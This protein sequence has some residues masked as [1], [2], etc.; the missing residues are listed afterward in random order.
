MV[1]SKVN[2]GIKSDQIVSEVEKRPCLYD[3]NHRNYGDRTEKMRSW[4]E[5]CENVVPGWC[6]LELTEKFAAGEFITLPFCRD[7]GAG[8]RVRRS[9][10]LQPVGL[11]LS[12]TTCVLFVRSDAFEMYPVRSNVCANMYHVPIRISIISSTQLSI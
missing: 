4:E 2:D 5:V 7:G 12:R 9:L 10:A 6:T 3:T 1:R 8:E 11:Q